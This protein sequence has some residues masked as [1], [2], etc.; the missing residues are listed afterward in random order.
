MLIQSTIIDKFLEPIKGDVIDAFGKGDYDTAMKLIADAMEDVKESAPL[1]E[2]ILS[3][4]DPYFKREEDESS[5]SSDA[6][7]LGNGIKG[8]TEETASLLASYLNA[9]RADVSVMRALQEKGWE[10]IAALAGVIT[11]TLADY[12]QQIAAN[13]ANAAQDTNA[14]LA[15]LRSVIGPAGTTGD[16]LRVEMA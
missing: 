11:P 10:N 14:I 3:V 6:N 15:E 5:S 13:T 7:S 8:I 12:V 2:K 4:F 9:I 1:M 16:V